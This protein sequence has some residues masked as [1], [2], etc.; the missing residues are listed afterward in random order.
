MRARFVLLTNNCV[1][2]PRALFVCPLPF[3]DKKI[4][5]RLVV[6]V[7]WAIVRIQSAWINSKTLLIDHR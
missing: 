4:E 1:D 2:Q 3:G 7:V 5:Q 6:R